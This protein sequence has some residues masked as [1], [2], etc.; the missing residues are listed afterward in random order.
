MI[1]KSSEIVMAAAAIQPRSPERDAGAGGWSGETSRGA[2]AVLVRPVTPPRP[3]P[4][5]TT[6]RT[7]VDAS[8][9]APCFGD[10]MPKLL[11]DLDYRGLRKL[12]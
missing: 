1:M 7:Y 10:C 11:E 9:C 12:R 5:P 6:L 3:L 8:R 2:L 4:F